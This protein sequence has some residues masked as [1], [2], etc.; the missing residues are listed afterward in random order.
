[1]PDERVEAVRRICAAWERGEWAAGREPFEDVIG[2]VAAVVIRRM[3][4]C[5]RSEAFEAT[6]M[7]A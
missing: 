7:R 2:A 5:D 6:G 3:V 4:L 1:M